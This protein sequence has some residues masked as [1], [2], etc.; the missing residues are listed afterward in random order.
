M[1]QKIF[2]CLTALLLVSC[3]TGLMTRGDV[4]EVENKKNVQDTVVTLQK[5]SADANNRFSEIESE[6]RNMSGRID[7]AEN[8]LN[9]A[10][11]DKDRNKGVSEQAL[12]DQSRKTQI[13]QEELIRTQEQVAALSA[14]LQALKSAAV[15]NNSSSS[16]RKDA[17]EIG[18]DFFEK[19]EWRR[20]ILSYQKYRD[21]NPKSK[22][23][24]DATYKIGV[25]FQELG[26]RDE[27]RTFYDE[28]VAKFPQSAEAKKART[29]LKSL[30]K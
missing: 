8:K 21:A 27:A 30:K 11:L 6:L 16:P 2:Y 14:E 3:Q 26:L 4:K 17:F 5:T 18:E 1:I 28:V 20:A 13:L 24:S 23:F 19:K 15:E 22:K 7:V 10:N 12:A 29:R 9:Q 25:S